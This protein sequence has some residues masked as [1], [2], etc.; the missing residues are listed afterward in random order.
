MFGFGWDACSQ[1]LTCLVGAFSKYCTT[2][3]YFDVK[4]VKLYYY[5]IYKDFEF[6]G[7]KVFSGM[8]GDNKEITFMKKKFFQSCLNHII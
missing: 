3:F 8:G 1:K 6:E 4:V 2:S 5:Y 7:K